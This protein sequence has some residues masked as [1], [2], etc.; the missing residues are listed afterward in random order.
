MGV[1]EGIVG[2]LVKEDAFLTEYKL[3]NLSDSD[4]DEMLPLEDVPFC[5][6]YIR[7]INAYANDNDS[8]FVMDGMAEGFRRYPLFLANPNEVQRKLLE[9]G[10]YMRGF[11]SDGKIDISTQVKA[12]A[13]RDILLIRNNGLITSEQSKR[14]LR[15]Q[16]YNI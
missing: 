12:I 6:F 11:V 4:I 1:D 15:L 10:S 16:G 2:R 13:I 9:A 5:H 3:D 14:L 7:M 8:R